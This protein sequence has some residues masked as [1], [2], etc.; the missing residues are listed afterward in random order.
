[1]TGSPFRFEM[2]LSYKMASII[3][4]HSDNLPTLV[5][6]NSRRSA[7]STA[8]IIVR[9]LKRWLSAKMS[10]VVSRELKAKA[11]QVCGDLKD[12]L[13][14]G[15]GFHHAGLSPHDRGLIEDLFR[16][17]K[18]RVLVSTTTLALGINLPAHLVVIKG[19]TQTG[20][21]EYDEAQVWQMIGRAGRPQFDTS[22]TAVIV[23]STDKKAHYEKLM[24]GSQ[25]VESCL[26]DNM[27]EHLNT[28]VVLGTITDIS[29]ALDWLK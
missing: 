6:V 1:M 27:C 14:A 13:T 20:S 8:G 21:R 15:V 11:T 16:A 12:C 10:F 5:F 24:S 29:L 4:T 28:E 9:D 26:L 17:G 7:A 23:T 18:L 3:Q 19:T 25:P 22:A 2:N